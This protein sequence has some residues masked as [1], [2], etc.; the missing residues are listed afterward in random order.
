MYIGEMV[1]MNWNLYRFGE[2]LLFDPI[3]ACPFAPVDFAVIIATGV[4]TYLLLWLIRN[5]DKAVF[6]VKS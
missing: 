1:M 5:R 6:S 3:G 4:I 2:G